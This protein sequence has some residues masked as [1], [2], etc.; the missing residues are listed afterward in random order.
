MGLVV[1]KSNIKMAGVSK[2]GDLVELTQNSWER[3][4]QR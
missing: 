1:T 4:P 3:S 2:D